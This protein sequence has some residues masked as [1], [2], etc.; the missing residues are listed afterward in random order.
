M[1]YVLVNKHKIPTPYWTWGDAQKAIQTIYR[2]Q[3]PVATLLII[4]EK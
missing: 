1:Y 2:A 4:Y 3:Y